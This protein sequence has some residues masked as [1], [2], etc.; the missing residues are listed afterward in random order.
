MFHEKLERVILEKFLWSG[1]LCIIRNATLKRTLPCY[2]YLLI[3]LKDERKVYD[4]RVA[5]NKENLK[6]TTCRLLDYSQDCQWHKLFD[7][8][9]GPMRC[10]PVWVATFPWVHQCAR[11]QHPCLGQIRRLLLRMWSDQPK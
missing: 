7:P 4:T 6:Q 10:Q 8:L 9:A 2:I 11:Q 3:V 1:F 5:C